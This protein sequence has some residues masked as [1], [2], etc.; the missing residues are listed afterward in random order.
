MTLLW[1]KELVLF[2]CMHN[3]H[4]TYSQ[5]TYRKIR[6]LCH[7]LACLEI[8]P[9][10]CTNELCTIPARSTGCS[11]LV[12]CSRHHQQTTR[13]TNVHEVNHGWPD[14][15]VVAVRVVVQKIPASKINT[16]C[17]DMLE[18]FVDW[19]QRTCEFAADLPSAGAVKCTFTSCCSGLLFSSAS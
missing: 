13:K 1:R 19:L 8:V 3:E 16:T 18:S 9:N 14:A 6:N 10:K 17:C 5:S 15:A 11:S 12:N 4:T 2:V 7:Q